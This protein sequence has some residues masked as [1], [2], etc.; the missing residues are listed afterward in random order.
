MPDGPAPVQRPGTGVRVAGGTGVLRLRSGAVSELPVLDLSADVL[1]LTRAL[2][3]AP[4]VSGAEG[5]LADAVEA[6]LR[7]YHR[8]N[9]TALKL[10]KPEGTLVTCSCSGLVSHEMFFEMLAQAAVRAG[11]HVQL[12]E[13]RGPSADHPLSLTCPETDYLKCYICRV[14]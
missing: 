1:T 10:L 5:P 7:G 9:E 11:R 4:S 12:L 14:A 13:R 3:D 2:V 8:M 6:A